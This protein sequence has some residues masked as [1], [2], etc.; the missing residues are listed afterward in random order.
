MD[1]YIEVNKFLNYIALI[2][3]NNTYDSYKN[4]LTQLLQYLKTDVPEVV[5]WADV[6][7]DYL[8]GFIQHLHLKDFT[9]S[10]IAR[11]TATIKTFFGWLADNKIVQTDAA[12]KIRSTVRENNTPKVMSENDIELMMLIAGKNAQP[13]ALRDKALLW[14]LY[15]TGMRVTEAINLQLDNIDL[16]NMTIL[17]VGRSDR[18]R[19]ITI[20]ETLASAIRT[21]LNYG[22]NELVGSKP[23]QFVFLNPM[24]L[25]LSR[26]SVWV[27]IKHYAHKAGFTSAITP[28]TLRHSRAVHL[29]KNGENIQHVKNLMGHVNLSTTK[30]YRS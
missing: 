25:R 28:H 7:E 12:S 6:N 20:S 29:L 26:Q 14:T 27:M 13:R 3:T 5:G 30:K 2:R 21:Y 8:L 22:R 10:S 17:C 16:E 19:S 24:G 9:K 4:D 11:K 15:E 18:P 23:C 1:L